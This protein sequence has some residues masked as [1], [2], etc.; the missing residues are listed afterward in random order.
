MNI[1]RPS[2]YALALAS[3]AT[4]G[5]QAQ[6]TATTDPVGFVSYNVNAQSDQK[7]GVPMQQ[8]SS[9]NGVASSVNAT[10]VQST[11]MPA[12]TGD[13]FLLVTSGAAAGQWEQISTS[14]AGQ[15]T[16]ASSITGFQAN[17]TF[18]VK[19]FWTLNTLFPNGGAIPASSDPENPVAVVLFNVPG[20]TGINQATGAAYLYHAGGV[21]PAGWY[22]ANTFE[23]ADSVMVNPESFITVRNS[24]ASPINI[25]FVGSVPAAKT[26]IDVTSRS[27]GPQDNLVYNRFPAD[28]TLSNSGLASSGAVSPSPDPEN[29]TDTV[30]VYQ[31]DSTGLNPA[32]SATYIYHAGEI[33]PAGWYN[34]N[35]FESAD[36]VSIPA[37]GAFIIR[38]PAG[39]NSV[40]SWNPALPY[41]LN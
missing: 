38:K 39:A 10:T 17:D 33:L 11:G 13:N 30:L 8:A 6:T 29:P 26:A 28:V 36:T 15:V 20:A 4:S 2:I 1:L 41:S 22:D 23:L 27:A 24:T 3:I 37:G 18:V 35:D 9:Y 19:P 34:A 14:S 7:I 32:S 21:L 12:L 31:T 40:I 16:I 5:L 25:S